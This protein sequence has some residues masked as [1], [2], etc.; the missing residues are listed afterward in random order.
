MNNAN[1]VK[2]R[3]IRLPNV[4]NRTGLARSTIYL[5]ISEG[6]FPRPISIGKRAVAWLESE[7]DDWLDQHV[8]LSR[9]TESTKGTENE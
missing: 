2:P 4:L 3:L 6:E 1:E 9:G 7:I 5:R 8:N